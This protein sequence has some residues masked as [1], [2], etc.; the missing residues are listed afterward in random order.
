[1]FHSRGTP[2]PSPSSLVN[3]C[4]ETARE[5]PHAFTPRQNRYFRRRA[6]SRRRFPAKAHH[7]ESRCTFREATDAIADETTAGVFECPSSSA[8]YELRVSPYGASAHNRRVSQ[9]R[10]DQPEANV[11]LSLSLYF[12][13][14][15]L[16]AHEC[17]IVMLYN[18]IH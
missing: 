1:M 14:S 2:S 13:L 11:D 4:F 18:G 9:V 17:C 3:K 6:L 7:V 16:A 5:F 8:R 10:F 12:I 15:L